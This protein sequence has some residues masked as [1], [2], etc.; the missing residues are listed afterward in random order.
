LAAAITELLG[1][2]EL[3]HRLSAAGPLR[4]RREFDL[5][6]QTRALEGLYR[7][8]VA[9][10]VSQ[11]SQAQNYP[12]GAPLRDTSFRARARPQS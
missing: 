3:W 5:V 1:N 9:S 4:V 11:G 8:T 7:E 2:A 10:R 6:R 12:N